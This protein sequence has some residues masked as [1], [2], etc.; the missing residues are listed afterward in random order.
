MP[1]RGNSTLLKNSR[2]CQDTYQSP[3]QKERCAA[4]LLL[5]YAIL[6][7]SL[8]RVSVAGHAAV[9]AS[10]AGLNE[11]SARMPIANFSRDAYGLSATAF[12]LAL[13]APAR[14]TI[15]RT[16]HAP[17]HKQGG[18]DLRRYAI[19]HAERKKRIGYDV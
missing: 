13:R 1:L 7:I 8:S 4:L 16:I 19:L 10:A 6:V 3:Q 15:R 18:H 9:R 2:R 5:R 11:K 14:W 17:P 12:S